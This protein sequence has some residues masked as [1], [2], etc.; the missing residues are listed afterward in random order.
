MEKII[1]IIFLV[2]AVFGQPTFA[3]F[4]ARPMGMGGAFTAVA[5]DANAPYW[6]PAGLALNPEV[7]FTAAT[8]LNNRNLRVGDNVMNLKL[9][10]E[11]DMNPF[12][13]IAGI[14]LASALALQG[15]EYLSDQGI[16][17]KGWG[18]AGQTTEREESMAEQVSGTEEVIS[19]REQAK[20]FAKTVAKGTISGVKEAAKDI[21]RGSRRYYLFNPWGSPVYDVDYSRQKA[22]FAGGISWLNDYNPPLNQN[23]NWY[24]FSLASGFEQRV[25]IGA[26]VNIYHLKKISTDISGLGGDLD[27]GIIAKPVDYISFGLTGKGLLTTDIQWQDN[28]KTRYEALVNG[29]VAINPIPS[30]TIAADMHNLFRQD[31]TNHYG[32]E[33]AI[34][35]G[36]VARAGLS[37]GSKTT[38][39]SL[40][41][42]N[43]IIDYTYLG[44]VY[45]KTQ[46]VGAN[47]RF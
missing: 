42:A 37:D 27:L 12:E 2:L 9:C 1:L 8:S 26:N 36:L 35:P 28:S 17:K 19:L 38:G 15:A 24:T 23:T 39:L 32:V 3:L 11:T 29:G 31:T 16:L 41:A 20:A 30:V 43:L 47:W 22:Q 14:G 25:A 21:I 45:N 5:N 4:G 7:S 13:W 33:A 18:R 34:M 40:A 6:N 46:M 44:G 10:Y